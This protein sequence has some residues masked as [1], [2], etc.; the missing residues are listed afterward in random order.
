MADAA[1]VARAADPSA[2]AFVALRDATCEDPCIGRGRARPCEPHASMVRRPFGWR[3]RSHARSAPVGNAA[4]LL[5][6]FV[7]DGIWSAAHTVLR[8]DILA[9][10]QSVG[11]RR[12]NDDGGVDRG[13]D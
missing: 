6:I 5:P 4:G 12:S 1:F 3:R 10:R 9:S 7:G 8:S 13:P 2:G 11:T